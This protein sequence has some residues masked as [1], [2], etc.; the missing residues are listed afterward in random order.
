MVCTTIPH[1][2]EKLDLTVTNPLVGLPFCLFFST[3]L[4][5]LSLIGNI[6]LN[7]PSASRFPN[8]RILVLGSAEYANSES[9]PTLLTALLVLILGIHKHSLILFPW[10]FLQNE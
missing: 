3:M 7:P 8:L 5:P 1:V 10:Q 4:V 6:F 9:L 2:M